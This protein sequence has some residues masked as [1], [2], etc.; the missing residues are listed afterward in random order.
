[1]ERVRRLASVPQYV[2]YGEEVCGVMNG[3]RGG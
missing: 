1:M 2:L 3:G